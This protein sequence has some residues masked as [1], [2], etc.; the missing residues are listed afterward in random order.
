MDWFIVNVLANEVGAVG[1][2]RYILKDALKMLPFYGWYFSQHSC[3]YISKRGA[4]ADDQ[5]RIRTDLA[6]YEQTNLPVSE[7]ES[8]GWHQ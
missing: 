1:R 7:R 5:R 8:N 3:V 2:I 6:R 4:W